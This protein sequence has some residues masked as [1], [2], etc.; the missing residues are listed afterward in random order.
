MGSFLLKCEV[1]GLTKNWEG[2]SFDVGSFSLKYE[3]KGFRENGRGG[4]SS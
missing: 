3:V 1:K 2:R 4:P